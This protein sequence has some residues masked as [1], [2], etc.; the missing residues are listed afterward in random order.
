MLKKSLVVGIGILAFTSI[1]FAGGSTRN[2]GR[3][4]YRYLR[5]DGP[6]AQPAH[7]CATAQQLCENIAC[8]QGTR[9]VVRDVSECTTQCDDDGES[10]Y[11]ICLAE[12][13]CTVD[14]VD[15]PPPPPPPPAPEG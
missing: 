5:S 3:T 4:S 15:D 2:T 1:A 14:C 11:V 12:V 10:S 7:A 9:K 6:R 8:F 13:S